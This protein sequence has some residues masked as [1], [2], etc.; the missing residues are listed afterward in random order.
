MS[1][2]KLVMR[3]ALGL[4]KSALAPDHIDWL[5]KTLTLESPG[6]KDQPPTIAEAYDECNDFLW[7]PRYYKHL[8]WW[9]EVDAWEWTA[10]PLNYTL[11][12]N[13]TALPERK[14]PEAIAAMVSHIKQHS[15]GIAV[16]PT[17]TGKT[18]LSLEIARH[19]NTPIGVLI[20]AG[21]QIDNWKEHAVKHLGIPEKDIGLIKE[22]KCSIG[23]PLTLISV[24]TVLCR[25]LPPE[26][27]N[28][29]GF[30]C[31]DEIHRFGAARWGSV[32][33]KFPARYR[34]GV[35][36]DPV[37]DDGLDPI[38]R[39][40]FGKVGYALH[41]RPTGELPTVCLMR[42]PAQYPERSYLDF[43]KI[44]KRWLPSTPNFQ[45]YCKLL[46][47]DKKRNEWIV[48]N[49]IKARS[50]GRAILVF[51]HHR[52]HLKELHDQFV[53]RWKILRSQIGA[54]D[55][56][57]VGLLWG[58]LKTREEKAAM[59]AHVI[60]TTHGYAREALNLPHL[61]TLIFGTPPGNPLQP[62]GR[63]R[64]KGPEDR[65]SLLV[66]DP[67]ECGDYPFRKAMKRKISY[68]DLGLKVKR[69]SVKP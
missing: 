25:D 57:R 1:Q 55:N 36:A 24:Q 64:D 10:P 37:R 45:K 49:I 12:S 44:G 14:Q 69:I 11:Q 7:T 68:E 66:I 16:L 41:T 56:T 26:A 4:R 35:S 21:H 17:G 5:K 13:F 30:I 20:Y 33:G 52:K 67:F 58:G 47:K 42:Y 31:A 50:K 48:D 53:T 9:P 18:F 59:Q 6:F 15:G 62:V 46:A 32:V 19:F 39:W 3:G 28:Q 38:I 23:K 8:D 54:P 43:K 27:L 2:P 40:N 65:K 22:G 34:L 63:L 51:T 60:F 29:F 61:D